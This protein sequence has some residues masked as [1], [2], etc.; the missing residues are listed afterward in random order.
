VTVL[1]S[2]LKN[3]GISLW[4]SKA[5]QQENRNTLSPRFHP[6]SVSIVPCQFPAFAEV[7]RNQNEITGGNE[8]WVYQQLIFIPCV[9]YQRSSATF[10]KEII[11][12]FSVIWRSVPPMRHQSNFPVLWYSS[13]S[14]SITDAIIFQRVVGGDEREPNAS[15]YILGHPVTGR[16]KY[17]EFAL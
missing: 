11:C 3:V 6:G 4:A 1:N 10:V 16:L 13:W 15:G 2:V 17:R 9:V 14:F 12:D 5:V 7:D 8:N